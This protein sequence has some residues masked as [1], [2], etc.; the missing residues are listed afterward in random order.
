MASIALDLLAP[1]QKCSDSFDD[2]LIRPISNELGLAEDQIRIIVCWLLMFPMGWFMHFCVRGRN[3]RHFV[4]V[5]FGTVGITY[6][7]GWEV[8]QVYAMTFTT[9]MLMRFLPRDKS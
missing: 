4:N 3:F 2:L 9:W 1:L 8:W 5:L 6:F 7:F